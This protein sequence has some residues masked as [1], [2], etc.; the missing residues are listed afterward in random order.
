MKSI[1][2]III[3]FFIYQFNYGCQCFGP[4]LSEKSLPYFDGIYHVKIDSI[5]LADE[6]KYPEFAKD[7]H[8]MKVSIVLT[9]KGHNII[10]LRVFGGNRKFGR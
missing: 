10:T 9:Y 3:S 4:D 8:F 7:D 2:L 5:F 1:T 6:N